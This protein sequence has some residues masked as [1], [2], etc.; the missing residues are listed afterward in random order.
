MTYEIERK[1]PGQNNFAKI[2]TVNATGINF[3]LQN[4]QFKDTLINAQAGTIDY[5]I[6]E[7]NDGEVHLL[8][9][10]N[11]DRNNK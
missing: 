3:S 1:L 2:G 7:I 5:R 9:F 6:K 10:E 11:N 8:I 4:Y